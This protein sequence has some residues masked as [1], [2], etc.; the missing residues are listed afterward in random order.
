MTQ[1]DPNKKKQLDQNIKNMLANGASEED[2]I[3]YSKDFHEKFSV[4]KKES[5]QSPSVQPKSGSVPKTGSSVSN[6]PDIIA[7]NNEK[8]REIFN[9]LINFC[10]KKIK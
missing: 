1:I 8:A 2:V 3:K 10:K 4:K 9:C 6:V 7:K 5:S